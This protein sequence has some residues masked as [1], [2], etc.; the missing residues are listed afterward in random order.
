M[1]SIVAA[2]AQKAEIAIIIGK[3]IL[4]DIHGTEYD[5]N[6]LMSTL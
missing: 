3:Q 1:E 2:I 4:L 6:T 5:S